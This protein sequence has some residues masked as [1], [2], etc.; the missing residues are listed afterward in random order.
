M[1]RT[2]MTAECVASGMC[3]NTAAVRVSP[4]AGVPGIWMLDPLET[5]RRYRAEGMVS[6]TDRFMRDGQ[7][8]GYRPITDTVEAARKWLG[9]GFGARCAFVATH[10]VF[11]AVLLRGF[12]DMQASSAQWV[13]FLQGCAFFERS[14]GGWDVEYIV[15]DKSDWVYAVIQ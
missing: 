15:P 4:E 2:M 8:D 3:A 10:D 12:G 1:R 6:F 9:R 5:H 7:A 13:G 11:A 14:G